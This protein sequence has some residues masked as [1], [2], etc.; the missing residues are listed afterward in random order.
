MEK[1]S[2]NDCEKNA[3]RSGLCRTHWNLVHYGK[4]LNGCKQPASQKSG[5][6]TNCINRGNKAPEKRN[7]GSLLNNDVERV[8]SKCKDVFEINVFIKSGHKNRCIECQ[9]QQKFKDYLKRNYNLTVSEYEDL[10][11][12][13]C[14]I[15]GK[16]E[17]QNNKKLSV[18]HDHEC[19]DGR[20]SCGKCIRGVLCDLCN[21][22]VGFFKNNPELGLK[23]YR[24]LR[25]AE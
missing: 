7:K 17:K 12:N 6:C 18:D 1:C 5:F 24:Y 20:T 22:A 23:M 13:G 25:K 11:K 10:S 19:C 8:C 14:M 9:K 16:D 15:C 4:C 21:R 2:Y 3:K